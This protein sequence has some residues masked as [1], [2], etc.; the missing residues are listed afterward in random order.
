MDGDTGSEKGLKPFNFNKLMSQSYREAEERFIARQMKFLD[1]LIGETNKKRKT[2]QDLENDGLSYYEQ[3]LLCIDEGLDFTADHLLISAIDCFDRAAKINPTSQ[4]YRLEKA[5]AV[6]KLQ[7]Y[8]AALRD[9]NEDILKT[10][11]EAHFLKGLVYEIQKNYCSAAEGFLEAIRLNSDHQEALEELRKIQPF[12][13]DRFFENVSNG[14]ALAMLNID[15]DDDNFSL[16]SASDSLFDDD[17]DAE[18][19]TKVHVPFSQPRAY[20]DVLRKDGSSDDGKYEFQV[21]FSSS[22]TSTPQKTLSSIEFPSSD[23]LSSSKQ[24]KPSE[25]GRSEPSEKS[26]AAVTAS[27]IEKKPETKVPNQPINPQKDPRNPE[28]YRTVWMGNLYNV[29]EKQLR[30]ACTQFGRVISVSV[31]EGK[32]YGF[33]NF[34][35]KKAASLCMATL[36]NSKIFG[37][38]LVLKFPP[39]KKRARSK[40]EQGR[41]NKSLG[42]EW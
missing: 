31:I 23:D 38:K 39:S 6:L 24:L 32:N 17:S 27:E 10:N 41:K 34:S 36:Q 2:E 5:I 18:S 29:T 15:S 21:S 37:K 1:S 20:A 30:A 12:L 4:S 33:V 13:P 16:L 22:P 19:I 3:A 40:N 8:D 26:F 42:T 11:A 28:G 14:I 9:L 7:C 35:D 25:K